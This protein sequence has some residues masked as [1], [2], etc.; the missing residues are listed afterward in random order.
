MASNLTPIKTSFSNVIAQIDGG[1]FE[2]E[3]EGELR[4][5]LEAISGTGKG[6]EVTI[7]IKVKPK[8]SHGAVEITGDV[9]TKLPEPERLSSVF[10][11]T[12]EGNLSRRDPR[13]R[14]MF[15]SEERN[16]HNDQ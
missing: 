2:E 12:P 15:D 16:Q 13:Q 6:G 10:F 1:M 5:L 8:K 11:I 4:S 14:E 3:L 9:K 7:K